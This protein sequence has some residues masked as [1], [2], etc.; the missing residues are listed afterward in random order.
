MAGRPKKIVSAKSRIEATLNATNRKIFAQTELQ[1]IFK[2]NF[3]AWDLRNTMS[4]TEFAQFL[5]D[6]MGFEKLLLDFPNRPF[7]RFIWRNPSAFEVVQSL[8]ENGYFSHFSA[9]YLNGITLQVPKR[10]YFNIE[11]RLKGGGGVLTQHGLDQA[12]AR[13]CRVSNNIAK[14]F[15][16]EVCITNGQNTGRLGVTEISTT[17]GNNLRVTNFERTLI[18]ATVRPIYS[19][20][21]HEVADAFSAARDRVS[22]NKLV[23]YLRKINF[24]YPYHQAIGYYLERSGAYQPTQI[25]AMAEFGIEFN[26]YLDYRMAETDFVEKWKL[27]VP[28]GF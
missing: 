14:L 23:A 3:A 24:T 16:S 11:Q 26:F 5:I 12:F 2:E 6:E 20:G 8:D 28:K 9:L 21:V 18:D 4:F 13:E 17:E 7:T 22:I 25:D 1:K 10:I 19:G 15:N 27:F